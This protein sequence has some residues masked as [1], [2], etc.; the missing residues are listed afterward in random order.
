MLEL[1]LSLEFFPRLQS[2]DPVILDKRFKG[3]EMKREISVIGREN[4]VKLS[5]KISSVPRCD[6]FQKLMQ[7]FFFPL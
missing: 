7:I 2:N 3:N 4:E 1:N 5:H 6:F